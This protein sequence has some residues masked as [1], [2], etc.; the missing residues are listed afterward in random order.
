MILLFLIGIALVLYAFGGLLPAGMAYDYERVDFIAEWPGPM[1]G[2]AMLFAI[3]T[4]VGLWLASQGGGALRRRQVKE[5][6]A[7]TG[8][9]R[10]RRRHGV[11]A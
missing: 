8:L 2:L 3:G 6:A 9:V 7:H 4:L 11:G 1:L 5:T 10:S